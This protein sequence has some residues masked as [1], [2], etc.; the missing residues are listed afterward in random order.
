[1]EI[2]FHEDTCLINKIEFLRNNGKDNALY[3]S[4]LEN[5]FPEQQYI[6]TMITAIKCKNGR[7]LDM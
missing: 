5:N 4:Y 1:V 2:E 3:G 6:M 7:K